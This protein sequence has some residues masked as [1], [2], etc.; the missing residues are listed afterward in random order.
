M[1]TINNCL[2]E[3]EESK[4]SYTYEYNLMQKY[5]LDKS[6]GMS[7]L[8]IIKKIQI[9]GERD[10]IFNF[11][12]LPQIEEIVR[13]IKRKF[14]FNKDE[15]INAS[16]LAI[17]EYFCT[18]SI[19][20]NNFIEEVFLANFKD[21]INIKIQ[22]DIKSNY[23]ARDIPASGTK[24]YQT[25]SYEDFEDTI[26]EKL[27]IENALNKLSNRNR[28]ILELKVHDNLKDS[29]IGEVVNLSRSR[30]TEI[31]SETN[32]KMKKYLK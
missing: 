9:D 7:L 1:D 21:E 20:L 24:L 26:N 18:Q 10:Y 6:E 15:V 29:E 12:K 2:I 4:R 14:K 30:I 8:D 27:D 3:K 17:T 28:E 23:T 32:E 22:R 19:E 16:T 13:Q 25:I 11:I 5:Y 31:L